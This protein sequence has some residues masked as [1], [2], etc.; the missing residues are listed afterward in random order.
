MKSPFTRLYSSFN[1]KILTTS[2][3]M[4]NIV[5][6]QHDMQKVPRSS[7]LVLP[8]KLI[9]NITINKIALILSIFFLCKTL[10]NTKDNS[11]KSEQL[12]RIV[13]VNNGIH[14]LDIVSAL[15]P[16]TR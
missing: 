12:Q 9:I 8:I 10:E 13:I 16:P 4:N 5:L 6:N 14:E 11:I 3:I 15:I 1:I 7:S 2:N